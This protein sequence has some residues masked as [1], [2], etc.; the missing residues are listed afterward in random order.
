MVNIIYKK[1]SRPAHKITKQRINRTKEWQYFHIQKDKRQELI[2]R[3]KLVDKS[4]I[5]YASWENSYPYLG[6]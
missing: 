5:G 1:E 4:I 2:Q 6:G 3:N